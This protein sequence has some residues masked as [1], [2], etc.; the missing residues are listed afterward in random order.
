MFR[1]EMS[2]HVSFI[3]ENQLKK[4]RIKYEYVNKAFWESEK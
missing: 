4:R 2:P 1:Q 3:T